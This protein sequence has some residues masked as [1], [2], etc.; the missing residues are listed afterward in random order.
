[1]INKYNNFL[2]ITSL[3]VDSRKAIMPLLCDNDTYY[4]LVDPVLFTD[5]HRTSFIQKY[6]LPS[7]N[8]NDNPTLLKVKAKAEK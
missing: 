1:M 8:E 6:H 5:E 4:Y 3:T 2:G 7:F